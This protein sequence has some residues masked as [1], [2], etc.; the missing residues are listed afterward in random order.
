MKSVYVVF[1]FALSVNGQ[2]LAELNSCE[3]S[4][5][6]T[7]R[8]K[9][10]HNFLCP[11]KDLFYDKSIPMKEIPRKLDSFCSSTCRSSYAQGIK[12][13]KCTERARKA[14]TRDF[15]DVFNATCMKMDGKY[16]DE[17]YQALDPNHSVQLGLQIEY[18]K[19]CHPCK[20]K[21][22]DILRHLREGSESDNYWTYE[23]NNWLS[24]CNGMAD[25]TNKTFVFD[26]ISEQK[27]SIPIDLIQVNNT[28]AYYEDY[29]SGR[30]QCFESTHGAI[31]TPQ[32]Q[33]TCKI[34]IVE[35]VSRS[36][37]SVVESDLDK[38]CSR[39]CSSNFTT[40]L[41]SATP[42]C[43]DKGMKTLDFLF[44]LYSH[45]LCLKMDGEYCE[46]IL[47]KRHQSAG[48]NA[49]CHPCMKKK[50]E[51][52]DVFVNIEMTAYYGRTKEDIERGF[53][54][55][56][57]NG[58]TDGCSTSSL[59]TNGTKFTYDFTPSVKLMGVSTESPAPVGES[60][61]S[62]G[63]SPAPVSESPTP[64]G[65]SPAPV[66]GNNRKTNAGIKQISLSVVAG[67]IALTSLL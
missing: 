60:P 34:D 38:F 14:V 45:L 13:A 42:H 18:G 28:L 55:S 8:E 41:I 54:K 22:M 15:Q 21:K 37:Y 51:V 12:S 24:S 10:E 17:H 57:M 64:V 16:C 40:S 65:E 48:S 33:E 50:T 44:K 47:M 3:Q 2:T 11:T 30:D 36:N 43:T 62:V 5:S 61:T 26:Y 23:M 66:R 49:T 39:T 4:F 52:R 7:L 32:L 9:F 19:Q 53:I 25:T 63:K 35:R 59:E 31:L 20:K 56:V 46:T 67:L 29:P 6:E 27:N 58:T 1:A